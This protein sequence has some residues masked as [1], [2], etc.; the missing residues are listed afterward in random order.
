[1]YYKRE[2]GKE[3]TIQTEEDFILDALVVGTMFRYVPINT[4]VYSLLIYIKLFQWPI[5]DFFGGVRNEIKIIRPSLFLLFRLFFGNCWKL[6]NKRL[7]IRLDIRPL[8]ISEF[9]LYTVSGQIS[10]SK[11]PV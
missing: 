11:W 3:I 1:M 2:V 4:M 8:L 7:R 5:Q 10:R 9:R 6:E